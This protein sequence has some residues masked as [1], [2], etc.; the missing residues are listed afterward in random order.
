M[1]LWRCEPCKIVYA[2]QPH[3]PRCGM[4]GVWWTV[5]P[6]AGDTETAQWVVDIS[7]APRDTSRSC[8]SREIE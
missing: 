8:A 3:C 4:L 6:R 2:P 1:S 7:P 5:L